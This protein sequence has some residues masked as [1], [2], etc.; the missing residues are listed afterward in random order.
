MGFGIAIFVCLV[1]APFA[2]M[3]ARKVGGWLRIRRR[4]R[5]VQDRRF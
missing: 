1:T 3:I 4:L 5:D 2:I